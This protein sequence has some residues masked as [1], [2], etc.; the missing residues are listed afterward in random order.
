M[1]IVIT[2][3]IWNGVFLGMLCIFSTEIKYYMD[4]IKNSKN[5]CLTHVRDIQALL[6]GIHLKLT[7]IFKKMAKNLQ[8]NITELTIYN[9]CLY[10]Y[11]YKYNRKQGTI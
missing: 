3:H 2:G 5:A 8:Q 1:Y 10:K 6:C 9:N 7:I 4:Y 11:K